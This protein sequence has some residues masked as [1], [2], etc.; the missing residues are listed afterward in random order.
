MKTKSYLTP[1]L[2][3]L[4]KIMYNTAQ[5][6]KYYGVIPPIR[7][8]IFI[9][10]QDEYMIF[11]AT[12]GKIVQKITML[13]TNANFSE[14][15]Q[16]VKFLPFANIK[17]VI[18]ELEKNPTFDFSIYFQE[19]EESK[20]FYEKII[21]L[22]K[23]FESSEKSTNNWKACVDLEIF[24]KILNTIHTVDYLNVD[25]Y[26]LTIYQGRRRKLQIPLRKDGKES[27]MEYY[28]LSRP[29]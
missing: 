11:H 26:E 25:D 17:E 27:K 19:K 24:Y 28:F 12:S 3:S 8:Y 21:E 16:G 23:S 7:N 5:E 6:V 18:S 13:Q 1:Y 2:K 29:Q 15:M 22:E 4:H 10:F 20:D 9:D 14:V